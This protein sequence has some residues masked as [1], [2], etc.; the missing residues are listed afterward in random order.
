[1][2][3][4]HH[5]VFSAPDRSYLAIVKKEIHSFALQ[6][7]FNAKKQAELDIIVAEIAS[8][9]VKHAGGGE[10]LVRKLEEPAYAGI[11][12]ISIDNG[13]GMSDPGRMVADGTSTTNTLG[14]GLGAIKRLSDKFEL[15]SL[16]NWGTILL[17]RVYTKKPP[18]P[19]T[20]PKVEIRPVVVPKP[21]ESECGDGYA[22]KITANGLKLFLGDG[23]GHGPEA[24][25]AVEEAIKTF[26]LSPETRPTD[27]LRSMH[28]AVRKTRGLV[29]TI[30]QFDFKSRR[31]TVCGI[32]NI[33]TRFQGTLFSKSHM[34]YNG[35]IGMNIPGT[36]SDQ[37]VGFEN[38]QLVIMCSD[39]I[40]SRWDLSKYPAIVNYDLSILAAALYKDYSR[41]TDDTSV[42]VARIG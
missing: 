39:G 33:A 12:L 42:V 29:G 20:L 10:I 2:G 34:A 31:W 23:L 18:V 38:G 14:Q 13:P 1:M 9:L 24:S 7:E 26:Q 27:L 22:T 5:T 17:A 15:Y 40:K 8:N 37:E 36:M 21:G 19:A 16:K 25:H 35:I 28:Q 41:R 30:L 4:R 32:G 11:E 3:N 6:L